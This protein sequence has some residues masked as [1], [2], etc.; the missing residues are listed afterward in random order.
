MTLQSSQNKIISVAII[1]SLL[2]SF[3]AAV[4]SVSAEEVRKT[5][6]FSDV[7]PGH[8]A[9]K[10]IAKLALQKIIQGYA[11]GTFRPADNVS[12]EDAV[13]MAVRFIG[14]EQEVRVDNA[15]VFPEGFNVK[16]YA[17]PY[18][19]YAIQEGLLDIK[20]FEQTEN[21]DETAWGS[22]KATREWVT[23]LIVRA[24]GQDEFAKEQA[25]AAASFADRDQI[26]ADYN[27][28]VNA[29]V[30]LGLMKGVTAD[31]FDPKGNVNRAMMATLLSRAQSAYPVAYS[32]QATG[33]LSGITD[34]TISLYEEG[35]QQERTYQL[36]A[37]SLFYRYDSELP[38][39]AEELKLYTEV[40]V[41][42]SGN[43]VSYIEQMGDEEQVSSVK[44]KIASI[45]PEKSKIF[46]SIDNEFVSFDYNDSLVIRNSEGQKLQLSDL[47]IGSDVEVLNDT[48]RPE[49][50]TLAIIVQG[51]PVNKKAQ[52]LV[53]SV[54][55]TSVT[56][57]NIETAQEET[58]T[59]SS[60]ALISW[61]GEVKTMTDIIAGDTIDY[62]VTNS[63]ITKITITLT[64][65]KSIKGE[66]YDTSS[67]RKT[68]TYTVNND[69]NVRFVAAGVQVI[70]EGMNQP[71]LSDLVRGDQLEMTVNSQNIVT[72]IKVTNRKVE[73]LNGATIVGYIAD[74]K[75]LSFVDQDDN[76]YAVTI[77][78]STKFVLNGNE[79]Q[80]AAVQSMLTSNR[81]V[82]I[83]YT[84]KTAVFIQFVHQYTGKLASLN[85]S[86]GTMTVSLDNGSMYTVNY[87]SPYVEI[88]GKATASL[89]DL[90]IGDIVTITLDANQDKASGIHVNQTLQQEIV[91]VDNTTKKIKLKSAEGTVVEWL[92]STNWQLLSEQGAKIALSDFKAGQTVNVVYAGK[93]PSAIKAV[94]VSIGKIVSVTN[95][96]VSLTGTNG[97]VFDLTLS[98][99]FRVVK[100]GVTSTSAAAL[101]PGDWIDVRLD[102]EETTVVTVITGLS[103]KFSRYDS[104]AK[105]LYV[106][107]T[108]ISDSNIRFT[109]T[110]ETKFTQAGSAISVQ[111]LK[112][113]DQLTLYTVNGK[114]IEVIKTP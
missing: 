75:L 80:L 52:G 50:L 103:R 76:P 98:A 74:R 90:K 89:S 99:G 31:K 92:V 47:V 109:V 36:T 2:V 65:G 73:I 94:K 113:G 16:D 61:N 101:A 32:G 33:L 49:P 26:G 8:W 71:G 84:E 111:S 44:G 11:G 9:E 83:G 41:I 27:G 87:A 7:K 18:V 25:L 96:K 107:A 57:E 29:A 54:N 15:I 95:N 88:Y 37:D 51:S 45:V 102:T 110:N 43:T 14:K 12:Q 112:N 40:T 59:V 55:G 86:A 81:K 17:K 38:S 108:N 60:Q 5:T 64:S 56:L 114:L 48:F 105:Q 42:V 19:V 35:Q 23:K 4:Q 79:V 30:S 24:I 13:I 39:T 91:S 28:Y 10:H 72:A 97:S 78:N 20:E 93:T 68:I 53:K 67:D 85:Q 63:Q 22:R 69:P 82:T 21:A 46:I 66:F 104:A 70:I 58:W 1:V 106:L 100:D 34:T 77:T 6:P 62:E 3:F